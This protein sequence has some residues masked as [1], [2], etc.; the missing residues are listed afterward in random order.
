MKRLLGALL[1]AANMAQA[2][3]VH[4]FGA[5]SLPA[6]RAAHADKPWVLLV[7]S[8]DCAYCHES[9]AALAQ[10]QRAHG[11]EVVALAMDRAGDPAAAGAI[12]SH[13][14]ASGLRAEIW[15]FGAAPAERLRYAIDPAWRGEMPRS[16]WYTP[17]GKGAAFSGRITPAVVAR[18]L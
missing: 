6:I 5:G 15:A 13:L 11:V 1:L 12:E 10:A 4:A 7:W 17:K 18:F 16:Y 9:F 8:L 2:A 3:P 14:A